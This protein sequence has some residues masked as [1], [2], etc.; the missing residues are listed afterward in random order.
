MLSSETAKKTRSVLEDLEAEMRSYELIKDLER[1]LS[2]YEHDHPPSRQVFNEKHSRVAELIAASEIYPPLLDRGTVKELLERRQGWPTEDGGEFFLAYAIDIEALEAV[3]A[4]SF[5]NGYLKVQA[6]MEVVSDMPA[7]LRGQ[8]NALQFLRD[9][10][11]GWDGLLAP[12]LQIACS[13]LS[14]HEWRVLEPYLER[15]GDYALLSIDTREVES[16]GSQV[17]ELLRASNTVDEAFTTYTLKMRLATRWNFIFDLDFDRP[18]IDKDEFLG[19]GVDY[20]LNDQSLSDDWCVCA[21]D[22]VLDQRGVR[23][24]ASSEGAGLRKYPDQLN[25]GLIKV[26]LDP[27]G[28]DDSLLEKARWWTNTT[29]WGNH[30]GGSISGSLVATII[31][32]E[33]NLYGEDSSFPFTK[34]LLEYAPELPRLIGMLLESASSP[35]YL[36]MLLSFF[37]TSHIGL[38]KIYWHIKRIRQVNSSKVAYDKIW[39]NL[40]WTQTLEIYVDSFYGYLSKSEVV[41]GLENICEAI[42]SIADGELGGSSHGQSIADTFLPSI[43]QAIMSIRYMEES[44]RYIQLLPHHCDEFLRIIKSR[45]ETNRE[46]PG[47]IPLGEWIAIFWLLKLFPVAQ[48]NVNTPSRSLALWLVQ[49]YLRVLSSLLKRKCNEREAP[50]AFDELE[51][52]CLYKA[53]PKGQQARLVFVFEDIPVSNVKGESGRS[54]IH[55]VRMHLR[56]LLALRTPELLSERGSIFEDEIVSIVERYGF[57]EGHYSGA[58]DYFIDSSEHIPLRLWQ[59][60]CAVANTFEDAAF[61][62]LVALMS[63]EHVPLNSLF[64][65]LEKTHVSGRA[66]LVESTIYKRGSNPSDVYWTPQIFD[67][68]SK[69]ANNGQYEIANHYIEYARKYSH[70]SHESRVNHLSMQVQLKQIFDDVSLTSVARVEALKTFR[71]DSELPV[72]EVAGYYDYL[73]ATAEIDVDVSSAICRFEH[74]SNRTGAIRDVTGL[75]RAVLEKARHDETAFNGRLYC[76]Q[77][78]RAYENLQLSSL[79]NMDLYYILTLSLKILDLQV[80]ERFWNVASIQ[81]QDSV[82]ISF[83]RCGYLKSTGRTGEAFDRMKRLR[84]LHKELPE[85]QDKRV[86]AFERELFQSNAIRLTASSVAPLGSDSLSVWNSICNM[87]AVDQVRIFN[88]GIESLDEYVL[89]VIN[90]VG[91]ELLL[92]RMHLRRSDNVLGSKL[93]QLAEENAINDWFVSLAR[94]RMSFAGWAVYDQSRSGSSASREGVGEVDGWIRDRGGKYIA[95]IEAFRLKAVEKKVIL[96]HMNKIHLYNSVGCT[97]VLVVV[98]AAVSNFTALCDRYCKFIK[99][100]S[101][102]GFKGEGNLTLE[103]IV[104]R[105]SPHIRYYKEVRLLNQVPVTFY[106]Q[107]LNLQS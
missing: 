100:Q 93:P 45:S 89:D 29:Q 34:R 25:L 19:A 85:E 12:Q 51:W 99:K 68:I 15:R 54:F 82:E 33:E 70:S 55:G 41:A 90:H 49:S 36:C 2:L 10:R 40:L 97:T 63:A 24:I 47:Q 18:G 28:E 14:T 8:L 74:L 69:A 102:D 39:Q 48:N 22:V 106:H 53:L 5:P 81:Q 79:D 80:F 96:E 43:N 20:V 84:L 27:A 86:S 58:L 57:S 88:N 11:A 21:V 60:I 98:Y 105:D 59:Q 52:D 46:S 73:L 4:I 26:M 72:S 3:R 56:L 30:S 76:D 83:L 16:V 94:H 32:N 67:L 17:W 95:L 37:P 42:T 78:V 38:V 64:V 35:K 71:R 77:W 31:R 107:L 1:K 101:Y 50:V 9:I 65:F 62:R 91:M 13:V 66:A 7:K 92:R 87:H 103:R 104:S 23:Q 61:K 75:V 6:S 44:G